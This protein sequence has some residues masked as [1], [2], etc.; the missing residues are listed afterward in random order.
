MLIVDDDP[1]FRALARGQLEAA[2]LEVTGE[3]RDAEEAFALVREQAPDAVL[4]DVRL[5]ADNGLRVLERL[6]ETSPVRV[7]LVSADDPEHIARLA[8]SAGADAF[9]PKA[10]LSGERLAAAVTG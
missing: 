7:V 9:V 2:G 4:L 3:A 5:G 10:G 1:V 8:L 6:R